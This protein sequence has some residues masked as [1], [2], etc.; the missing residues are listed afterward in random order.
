MHF[1]WS[2]PA[3]AIKPADPAI[4]TGNEKTLPARKGPRERSLIV[5]ENLPGIGTLPARRR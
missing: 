1:S 2:L 5:Q 4:E 3:R